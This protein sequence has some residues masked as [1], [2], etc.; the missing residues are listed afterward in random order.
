MFKKNIY[1]YNYIELSYNKHKKNI[2]CSFCKILQFGGALNF[3]LRS[4]ENG[5]CCVCSPW[6]SFVSTEPV[7]CRTF[8]LSCPLLFC[9]EPK[10]KHSL[11]L[12]ISL[13]NPKYDHIVCEASLKI[14]ANI[15]TTS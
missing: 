12:P 15:I 7:W 9:Q 10:S 2:A 14:M 13:E 1:I 3:D 8:L 4:C 6:P 5:Q 11:T